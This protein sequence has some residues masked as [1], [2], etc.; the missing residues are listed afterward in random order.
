MKLP[1]NIKDAIKKSGKHNTLAVENNNI[2]RKWLQEKYP[3]M[4]WE[5]FLIDSIEQTIDGSDAL[6][7]YLENEYEGEE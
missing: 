1:K 6:I 5:D 2:V 7:D 4:G 3:S